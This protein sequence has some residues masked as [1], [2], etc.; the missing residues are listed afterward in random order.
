MTTKP[1][2]RMREPEI[3]EQNLS[4]E[5]QAPALTHFPMFPQRGVAS[6]SPAIMLILSKTLPKNS[7]NSVYLAIP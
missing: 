1:K 4:S 5:G 2:A 7:V 6:S 3:Q